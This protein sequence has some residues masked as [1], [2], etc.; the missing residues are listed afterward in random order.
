MNLLALDVTVDTL[1]KLTAAC[2]LKQRN[3]LIKKISEIHQH[4][5]SCEQ[6]QHIKAILKLY[7]DDDAKCNKPCIMAKHVFHN[8]KTIDKSNHWSLLLYLE[9]LT[10]QRHKPEL[11]LG[12]K[13]SKELI[14]FSWWFL[15]L[16]I[17]LLISSYKYSF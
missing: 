12:I 4:L 6:F 5:S 10:I 7:P 13:A 2:T 15:N 17:I 8:T 16:C 14:V 11:N 3:I 9:S 1:V